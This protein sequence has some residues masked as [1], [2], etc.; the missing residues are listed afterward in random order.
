MTPM[1]PQLLVHSLTTILLLCLW[2]QLYTRGMLRLAGPIRGSTMPSTVLGGRRLASPPEL[3]CK[4]DVDGNWMAIA[5]MRHSEEEIWEDLQDLRQQM[6]DFHSDNWLQEYLPE[7]ECSQN[8]DETK[9]LLKETELLEREYTSATVQAIL[10]QGAYGA[11]RKAVNLIATKYGDTFKEPCPEETEAEL[12]FYQSLIKFCIARAKIKQLDAEIQEQC[13]NQLAGVADVSYLLVG[14]VPERSRQAGTYTSENVALSLEIKITRKAEEEIARREAQK[15][16]EEA[17]R[18]TT[19]HQICS[20]DEHYG[21]DK[22]GG[23]DKQGQM[24]EERLQALPDMIHQRLLNL[25]EL[26][27]INCFETPALMHALVVSPPRAVG[28]EPPSASAKMPPIDVTIKSPPQVHREPLRNY[29]TNAM[30]MVALAESKGS[31]TE[32][33]NRTLFITSSPQAVSDATPTKLI[34]QK[35]TLGC[36]RAPSKAWNVTKVQAVAPESTAP[37]KPIK[38]GTWRTLVGELG[39]AERGH[40]LGLG[41]MGCEKLG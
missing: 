29:V 14:E 17:K 27:I 15:E 4:N 41:G 23:W 19:W 6:C 25:F 11:L 24:F 30:A 32:T 31:D 13:E 38:M 28:K 8:C 21:P 7:D 40:A 9:W 37:G 1:P 5:S 33:P 36:R 12:A 18:E 22:C 26:F 39:D 20:P 3:L 16:K 35:A 10:E 2:H 34:V